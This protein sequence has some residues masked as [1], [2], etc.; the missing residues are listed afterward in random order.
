M[1]ISTNH[2]P[3][4]SEG[5]LSSKGTQLEKKHLLELWRQYNVN[6]LAHLDLHLR[7][8]NWYSA[9]FIALFGGYIIGLTQY[10]ESSISILFL[11][12]PSFVILLAQLGKKALD[13]FYRRFLEAVVMIAKLEYLL[14]LDGAIRPGLGSTGSCSEST[15]TLWPGDKYFIPKRYVDARDDPKIKNSE[16][17]VRIKMKLGANKITHCTFLAFQIA[18]ALLLFGGIAGI[19]LIN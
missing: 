6:E 18:A 1:S 14:G 2:G 12:L 16:D 10:L 8:A 19:L 15:K 13:R 5:W 11:V 3:D 7:Y 9:F 4:S 17:F